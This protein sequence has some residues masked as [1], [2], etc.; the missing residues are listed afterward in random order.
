MRPA[1]LV[2][3]A[4]RE[5]VVVVRGRVEPV[6]DDVDGVGVIGLGRRRALLDDVRERAVG[7]HLP[8]D[9]DV[10]VGHAA[11]AVG[12]QRLGRQA[13]PQHDGVGTGVTRRHAQRER[14]ARQVG[15]GTRRGA[16]VRGRGGAL[17]VVAAAPG[18]P[19]HD[20]G[21][22]ADQQLPPGELEPTRCIAHAGEP[23]TPWA[24]VPR[25]GAGTR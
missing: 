1:G 20:G 2:N 13:G 8:T 19:R 15:G 9:V 12:G 24:G 16:S 11:Q 18:H 17:T 3:D 21:G 4:N 22:R 10:L 14:V 25:T 23:C 7:G 6:D 5:A